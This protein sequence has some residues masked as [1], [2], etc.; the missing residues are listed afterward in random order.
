MTCLN[1]DDPAVQGIELP[2]EY[3]VAAPAAGLTAAEIR[4]AQEN[5]LYMAFLSQDEKQALRRKVA[6]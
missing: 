1:T 5:G 6:G 4:Q 3:Q 2:H